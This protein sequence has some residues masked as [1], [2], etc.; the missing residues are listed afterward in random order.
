MPTIFYMQCSRDLWVL[1]R[2]W[3]V[4]VLFVLKETT[5]KWAPMIIVSYKPFWIQQICHTMRY[6]IWDNT[7]ISFVFLYPKKCPG[8]PRKLISK[9]IPV[10]CQILYPWGSKENRFGWSCQVLCALTTVCKL[11][12]SAILHVRAICSINLWI[13]IPLAKQPPLTAK[14]Y[15]RWSKVHTNPFNMER[16]GNINQDFVG[17][18]TMR[19]LEKS[20]ATSFVRAG[21]RPVQSP[22][23]IIPL[24]PPLLTRECEFRTSIFVGT[25]S[26]FFSSPAKITIAHSIFSIL[27]D[28]SW[29]VGDISV[30]Q[31]IVGANMTNA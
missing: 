31:S 20:V 5:T 8:S 21:P 23:C 13:Q 6:N 3:M 29:K 24:V 27:K 11:L 26:Q 22:R 19:E 16:V 10:Q 25:C 1:M 30:H 15:R 17:I 28:I 14:H 12:F 7:W 4:G 2:I 9:R 18:I